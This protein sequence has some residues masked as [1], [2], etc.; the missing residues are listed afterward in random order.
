MLARA[1]MDVRDQVVARVDKTPLDLV[2]QWG[3]SPEGVLWQGRG[4]ARE[5][6]GPTTPIQGVYAV[7]AHATPG[8]GMAYVG[9]SAALVAEVIGPA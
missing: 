4:T 5:R 7:G 2:R 6:L 9:L 3:G 8:A 1:K